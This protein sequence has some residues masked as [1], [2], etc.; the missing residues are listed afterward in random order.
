TELAGVSGRAAIHPK[1]HVQ[2]GS[3]V[4]NTLWSRQGSL[5]TGEAAAAVAEGIASARASRRIRGEIEVL[6]TPKIQPGDL[7]ELDGLPEEHTAKDL[8]EG[9][10]LRARTVRHTLT[11]SRGFLTQVEF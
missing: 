5:R 8:L 6:G 11:T 2:K 4:T 1:G 3:Q 7:V 9:A 10:T